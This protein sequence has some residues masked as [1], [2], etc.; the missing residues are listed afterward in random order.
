MHVYHHLVSDAYERSQPSGG[1]TIAGSKATNPNPISLSTFSVGTR[2]IH[3]CHHNDSHSLRSHCI[4]HMTR[5]AACAGGLGDWVHPCL[6]H[7]GVAPQSFIDT[8]DGTT[9]YINHVHLFY[10]F[11]LYLFSIRLVF[12]LLLFTAKDRALVDHYPIHTS[13]RGCLRWTMAS[14]EPHTLKR[15]DH[16]CTKS[17]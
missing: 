11:Y 8:A 17:P 16:S 9:C 5:V 12:Y 14:Y 15:P 1:V 3:S 2:S 4:L 10:P 6:P 13:H 7:D